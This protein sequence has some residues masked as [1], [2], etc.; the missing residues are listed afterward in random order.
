MIQHLTSLNA[1]ILG[2]LLT[3]E[4]T[5]S[6]RHNVG[7][8]AHTTKPT[9]KEKPYTME[10]TNGQYQSHTT[11]ILQDHNNTRDEPYLQQNHTENEPLWLTVSAF[12]TYS[13]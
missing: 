4:T 7:A 11:P 3:S 13:T 10:T 5:L 9:H 8:H 1:P 2:Q 6:R 12:T